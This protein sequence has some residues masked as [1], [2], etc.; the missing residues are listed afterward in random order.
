MG[1][2]PFSL[3]S[4]SALKSTETIISLE[5]IKKITSTWE[6]GLT[7]L[8]EIFNDKAYNYQDGEVL[9]MGLGLKRYF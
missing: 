9:T 3:A 1:G 5:L 2:A 8:Y 7:S 4:F 6:I